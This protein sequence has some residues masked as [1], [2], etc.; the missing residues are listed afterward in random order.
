MTDYSRHTTSKGQ[1]LLNIKPPSAS[2]SPQAVPYR[3]INQSSPVSNSKYVPYVG[4]N[5]PTS[6]RH[7]IQNPIS[8]QSGQPYIQNTY[9]INPY[10]QQNNIQYI[11]QVPAANRNIYSNISQPQLQPQLQSDSRYRMQAKPLSPVHNNQTYPHPYHIQPTAPS[12]T[13]KYN[14]RPF[15]DNTGVKNINQEYDRLGVDDSDNSDKYKPKRETDKTICCFP[16]YWLLMFMLAFVVGAFFIVLARSHAGLIGTENGAKT[17]NNSTAGISATPTANTTVNNTNTTGGSTNLSPT[18]TT[19]PTTN[20]TSNP[21]T[22]G[23]T[24]PSTNQPS[25][26]SSTPSTEFQFP[27][28]P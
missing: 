17:D 28:A 20:G 18:P 8:V 23:T 5:T 13:V 19:L 2:Q 4:L 9:A 16:G 26:P 15:A 6:S 3:N 7:Q 12:N 21:A 25:T 22:G 24:Q 11:Q 27:V 1:Q 14:E 10:P